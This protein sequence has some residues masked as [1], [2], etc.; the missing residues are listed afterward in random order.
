MSESAHP[1]PCR[2]TGERQ[3]VRLWTRGGHQARRVHRTSNFS[4]MSP[5]CR[6][7]WDK[8]SGRDIE[9]PLETE[10]L[11]IVSRDAHHVVSLPRT[12]WVGTLGNDVWKH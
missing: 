1:C 12:T 5:V 7:P 2:G 6:V 10:I 9:G 8:S 4:S 3:G 11:Q